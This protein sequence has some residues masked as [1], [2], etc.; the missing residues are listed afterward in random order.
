MK[1][2]IVF[3]IGLF[4]VGCQTA[5]TV[6]DKAAP[7]VMERTQKIAVTFTNTWEGNI[8]PPQLKQFGLRF[9]DDL[10]MKLRP[11]DITLRTWYSS[12]GGLVDGRYFL[13]VA[14]VSNLGHRL[15]NLCIRVELADQQK[16]L[17]PIWT[18]WI[19]IPRL[20]EEERLLPNQGWGE[21]SANFLANELAQDLEKIG[22]I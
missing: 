19:W 5:T 13:Q 4:L 12:S 10:K 20:D 15:N 8:G 1:S 11:K 2:L 6:T 7:M 9:L 17:K 16:G 14:P 22:L 3:V 18:A 21:K